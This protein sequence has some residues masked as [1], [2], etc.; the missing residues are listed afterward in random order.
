MSEYT[1]QAN[2]FLAK[3]NTTIN[4]ERRKKCR[5]DTAGLSQDSHPRGCSDK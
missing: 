3:T 5:S 4:T 2:D 1:Q